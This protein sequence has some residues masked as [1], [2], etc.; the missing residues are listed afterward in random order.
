MMCRVRKEFVADKAAIPQVH[1]FVRSTLEAN[2]VAG[3]S[4]DDLVLACDEA[5]TNIVEHAFAGRRST[6]KSDPHFI[7]ALNCRKNRVTATFFDSGAKFDPRAVAA[8]DIRKNLAGERRG[9]YG[10][11]LIRRLVDKIVYS[12]RRRLNITRLVKEVS[13]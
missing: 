9:G 1:D 2:G 12:A 8:P 10:V 7:L 5:A 6:S 4:R 13:G 11:Y 3:T